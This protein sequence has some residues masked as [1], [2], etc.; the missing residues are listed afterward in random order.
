MGDT[1]R[2]V[3]HNLH[4]PSDSNLQRPYQT[5]VRLRALEKLARRGEN[6][7]TYSVIVSATAKERDWIRRE[8]MALLERADRLIRKAPSEE[9]FQLH[10]DLFTWKE[11]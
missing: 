2:V 4:L 6:A 9:V 5:L 10:F 3:R 11:E 1:Y 8:F 7:Y